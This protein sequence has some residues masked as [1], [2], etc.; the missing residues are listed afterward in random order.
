MAREAVDTISFCLDTLIV[1]N[2]KKLGISRPDQDGYHTMPIAVLGV[3]SR[4][5]TYYEISNFVDQMTSKDS[6]FNILLTDGNL[7]GEYGHPNLI[8][9]SPE[10]QLQRLLHID[11][12]QVS[13]HFK[14]VATGAV[15]ENGGKLINGVVK[16]FGPY[17]NSLKDNLENP[18]MNTAFSLRSIAGARQDGNISRRS[19]KKLV[20]FDAVTAGGYEA[21]AKRYSPSTE[22]LHSTESVTIDICNDNKLIRI[23]EASMEC[24]TDSELNDIFGAKNVMVGNKRL[25]FIN[26]TKTFIDTDGNHRSIY[27]EMMSIRKRSNV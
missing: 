8:G 22:D 23:S 11:E 18:F 5:G 27:Q 20:T 25:T 24:F 2:G 1:R 19:V 7:Y 13:H 10:A 3:D 21:A 15:L 12:K 16:P 26:G 6:R 4:N 17:G 9:L 14:S